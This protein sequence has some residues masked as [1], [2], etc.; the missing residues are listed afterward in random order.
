MKSF[1]IEKHEKQVKSNYKGTETLKYLIVVSEAGEIIFTSLAYMGNI[2]DDDLTRKCGI[3]DL[4]P[5]G[6]VIVS[7]KGFEDFSCYTDK[8]MQLNTPPKQF[9]T[10][11]GQTIG[12]LKSCRIIAKERIHNERAIGAIKDDWGCLQRKIRISEIDTHDIVVE[13]CSR[14]TTMIRQPFISKRDKINEKDIEKIEARLK[15]L[16]DED[17][18]HDG[19]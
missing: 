10:Q 2:S 1:L 15:I 11:K 17:A 14:L 16:I 18:A 13:V 12:Y 19:R 9:S 5:K 7:D 6:S 4:L 3:L 8:G